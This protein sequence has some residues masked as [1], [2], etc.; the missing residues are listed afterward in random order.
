MVQFASYLR[1]VLCKTRLSFPRINGPIEYFSFS[2]WRRDL[3]VTW[4]A[5]PREGLAVFRAKRVPLFL[6]HFKTLSIGL[7]LGIEPT[8]TGLFAPVTSPPISSH[9]ARS[10][11]NIPRSINRKPNKR[12]SNVIYLV[13]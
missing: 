12:A 7:A 2:Y 3:H 13:I 1:R 10:K 9:L 5:E 6:N 4:T 8:A 11:Y